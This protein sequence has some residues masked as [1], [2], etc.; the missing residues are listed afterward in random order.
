MSIISIRGFSISR[1][2][3]HVFF[4]I[5]TAI[6]AFWAWG[7]LSVQLSEMPYNIAISVLILA[8]FIAIALRFRARRLGWIWFIIAAAITALWYQNVKASNQRD[9]AFDV[10][11]GVGASMDGDIVTLTN[12][13]NFVWLDENTANESWENRTLDLSKLQSVDMFTSV[14]DNPSIA[15]LLISFG[16]ADGQRV[17]FSVETRKESH[18]EFSIKGGFFRQFEIVLLAATEE[19]I[20]KLRTNHRHEDVKL[21]PVDLS[22][23]QR[24]DLFLSYIELAQDLQEQP[25]F[26][27]TLTAN[28]TTTV[29]RLAQ[30]IKPGMNLDWRL[31]MSGHLPELVDKL[32]GF[33]DGISIEQRIKTAGI[34]AKAAAYSGLDYS[35]AIRK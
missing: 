12:V 32:G 8:S 17:T 20:V 24:Q 22:R 5:V 2:I 28:C 33:K 4:G 29:F 30:V 6:G 1:I 26:Y 9:W 25:Q 27:N 13:R 11:H 10:A 23:K 35:A 16:F 14:W 15:H 7:A 18:E 19:D 21:Y 34:T 3:G 31:I